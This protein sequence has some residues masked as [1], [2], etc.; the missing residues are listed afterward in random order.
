M[1]DVLTPNTGSYIINL[2]SGSATVSLPLLVK[3]IR[4]VYNKYKN[5]DEALKYISYALYMKHYRSEGNIQGLTEN[6]KHKR[7]CYNLELPNEYKPTEDIIQLMEYIN[8][9]M[10]KGIYGLLIQTNKNFELT[11]QTVVLLNKASEIQ[12]EAITAILDKNVITKEEAIQ[13]STA[14][15]EL[16][17]N[18][19]EARNL[20]LT[21]DGDIKVYKELVAKLIKTETNIALAH[22]G[23]QIPETAIPRRK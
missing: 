8:Y 22:G 23:G 14:S 16:L 7:A 13:L 11:R 9:D 5:K 17:G 19:K 18:L 6:E 1:L 10:T 12:L 21:L 4:D 2:D 15:K 3:E 20:N